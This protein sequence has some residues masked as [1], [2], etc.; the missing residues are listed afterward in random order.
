M[1]NSCKHKW[2]NMEDGSGDKFCV[3]CSRKAK[4]ATML[5]PITETTIAPIARSSLPPIARETITI[6][7]GNT[8]LGNVEVYADDIIKEINKEINRSARLRPGW[9]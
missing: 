6:H 2:V 7:T 9:I 8:N 5:L 1:S 3:K 4:Q